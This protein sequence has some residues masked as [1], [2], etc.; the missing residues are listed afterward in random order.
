M[1]YLVRRYEDCLAPG[2]WGVCDSYYMVGLFDSEEKAKEAAEKAEALA[3]ETDFEDQYDRCI[4]QIDIIPIE[5]NKEFN[6]DEAIYLGGG[7]YLE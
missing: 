2:N 5:V 6:P 7:S 3:K 1:M 4:T